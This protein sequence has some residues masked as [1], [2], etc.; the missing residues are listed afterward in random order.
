[1]KPGCEKRFAHPPLIGV[2]MMFLAENRKVFL[3][4]GLIST[5][6]S[7]LPGSGRNGAAGKKKSR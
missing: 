7:E 3:N 6:K 5:N 2:K 4:K 1:V